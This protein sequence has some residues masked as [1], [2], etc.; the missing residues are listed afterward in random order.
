LINAATDDH[1]QCPDQVTYAVYALSSDPDFQFHVGF[2]TGSH[3]TSLAG[4]ANI[5]GSLALVDEAI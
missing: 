1:S 3:P 5:G 2:D 4:L